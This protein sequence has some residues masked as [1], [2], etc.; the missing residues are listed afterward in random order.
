MLRF[1][2]YLRSL[3]DSREISISELSRI[4]GVE[5][6]S[7]QK[8]ITGNR[9]LARDAV[10]KLVWSLQL[11]PEESE[12]LRYYYD[13]FYIGEDKYKSREIIRKMLENLDFIHQGKIHSQKHNQKH[14]QEKDSLS[15]TFTANS[16]KFLE[17]E[18]SFIVGSSNVHFLV[19]TIF[20]R[21]LKRE[22]AHVE[23]TMP[24]D[25][26]FLNE[27][28]LYLYQESKARIDVSHIVAIHRR[29]K[30]KK[31]NLHSIESF[32]NLLPVCL[33]SNGQYNPYYYYDDSVSVLYTDP[34]PYFMVT[35]D[36]V[37]CMDANGEKALLLNNKEYVCCY[38]K[39]F[40]RLKNQCHA[41]V[42]Y[43]QGVFSSLEE[44][45]KLY[46]PQNMY[47]CV[48]QPCFACECSDEEIRHLI[49]KDIDGWEQI[50]DA[51]VQW[52]SSLQKVERYHSL[53]KAE[54]VISFMEDGHIDD[55]PEIAYA[56]PEKAR[57]D[58]LGRL[59]VSIEKDEHLMARM[60]NKEKISYP[61]FI[62]LSTTMKTGVGIFTT[63][64]YKKGAPPICIHVQE[65][66]VR[67]AFYDFIQYLKAGEL[68][69]SK[70]ETLE[71]LCE[72]QQIYA[73]RFANR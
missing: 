29:R 52:H 57:L 22:N 51:C 50:A 68:T 21:E 32:A 17:K 40:E 15:G 27:F 7:L 56:I 24:A 46:D 44:Y 1:G 34:F 43:N 47:V 20:Q 37:L 19:Q 12:K 60:F 2:T 35:R 10:E 4:S 53:F 25:M 28:L 70:A 55:F 39:H 58:I 71:Y 48:N 14:D 61:S 31:L 30:G 49:R 66:D 18:S 23:V 65:P 69:C 41:L 42:N 38:R 64:R 3:L 26:E 8:S 9:M 13:I 11:T 45:G 33:V 73:Q 6:T 59:I 72:I 67:E 16:L 54:G 62:T 63:S 5:R 36:C